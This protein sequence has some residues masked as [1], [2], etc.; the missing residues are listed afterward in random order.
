VAAEKPQGGGAGAVRS[1][2]RNWEV[3][4]VV[5][6]TS[7]PAGD[8]RRLSVAVLLNGRSI[9]KGDKAIFQPIPPEEVKALEETVKWYR[10]NEW[11]WRP[12]KER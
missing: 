8:I 9:K 3:Q 11:W 7:T 4:K 10:D 12:L 5:Q 2:T 1:Q 6:K